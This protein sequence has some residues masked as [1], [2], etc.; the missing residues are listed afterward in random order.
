MSSAAH[1]TVSIVGGGLA[2]GFLGGLIKSRPP[3]VEVSG[4]SNA[5]LSNSDYD[6]TFSSGLGG[7][8]LRSRR[9]DAATVGQFGK[10][11][12]S[13]DDTIA[14]FLDGDQIAAAT[15]ALKGFE[16]K[17]EGTAISMTDILSQRFALILGTFSD[18]IQ[19]FVREVAGLEGQ[20]QRLALSTTAQKIIDAA[21]DLFEGRTFREFIAVAEAMQGAGEDLTVTFQRLL[22]QVVTIA[23]Q[24]ILVKGF[25]DSDIAADYEA[26]V[27]GQGLTLKD[28]T[29]KLATG[30]RELSASFTGSAD[31]LAT[32]AVLVSQR[33]DSEIAYLQQIDQ[34]LGGITSGFQGLKDQINRN[35]FGDEAFYD[36]ITSQAEQ[37]AAALQSMTDPAKIAATV[38][39]IQRL[40]GIAYSLL[41]EEGKKTNG[42]GFLDFIEGVESDASEALQLAR[43]LFIEES[44]V[45]REMV[46]EMADAFADPLEIAATAH[47]DA[48]AALLTAGQTLDN[49]AGMMGSVAGQMISVVRAGFRDIA[50]SIATN[51]VVQ[52]APANNNHNTTNAITNA[53]V[54]AGNATVQ[55]IQS[56]VG[57][58]TVQVNMPSDRS[59]VLY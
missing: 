19:S 12:A 32:L 3:L 39:E 5:G 36:Q 47:E 34:I 18:D 51:S 38:A 29:S 45:L 17:M 9:V 16:V 8:F 53:I 24:L 48:A 40:T 4:T 52:G 50:D 7:G 27:S 11:L 21:P 14:S 1:R 54:A 13:F 42:A 46:Q 30:I 43:D 57:G 6:A 31:D 23:N 59:T 44:Q 15:A 58:I 35:L 26:L 25:A 33:Y 20:V 2:G 55:S 56:S 37:L 10:D 49:A 41:D 22:D 28:L